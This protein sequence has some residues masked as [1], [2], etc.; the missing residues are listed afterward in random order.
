LDVIFTTV[1]RIVRKRFCC[2]PDRYSPEKPPFCSEASDED[3]LILRWA[4]ICLSEKELVDR[5]Q[6]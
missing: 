5:G 6:T 1:V 3:A 4:W 2:G